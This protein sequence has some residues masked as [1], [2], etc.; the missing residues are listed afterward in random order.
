MLWLNVRQRKQLRIDCKD[1]FM[2][3]DIAVI[4]RKNYRSAGRMMQ[5]SA[6]KSLFAGLLKTEDT[7]LHN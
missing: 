5:S 3:R 2:M 4:P 7:D 1:Q 6:R